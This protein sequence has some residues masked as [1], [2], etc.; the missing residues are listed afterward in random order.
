MDSQ[1][2]W[3]LADILNPRSSPH[4]C[5]IEVFAEAAALFFT[6]SWWRQITV[7]QRVYLHLQI[8]CCTDVR[9]IERHMAEPGPNDEII[10]A[11]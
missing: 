1:A 11:Q 9:G 3:R 7:G 6:L 8:C 10:G 5:Y 4:S 2:R